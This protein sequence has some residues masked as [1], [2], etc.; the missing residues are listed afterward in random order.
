[1]NE[2]QEV[3]KDMGAYRVSECSRYWVISLALI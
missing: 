3:E 1:M 2:V